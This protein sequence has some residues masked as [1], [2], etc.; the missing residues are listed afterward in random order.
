[1]KATL[2]RVKSAK[3]TVNNEIIGEIKKGYMV[4]LGVE[5]DD[6]RE[7]INYVLNKLVSLRLFPND[8]GKFHYSISQMGGQILLVSQFTLCANLNS[9]RRPSF[10]KAASP[11][12]AREYITQLTK[13][14]RSEGIAVEEGMF[15]ASM[16]VHLIN[17]GPVTINIDSNKKN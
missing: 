10:S 5:K 11:E 7:D 6:N 13:L 12:K 2:Q 15:G 3:V 16:D 8:E 17:D 1:M 9:G 4:L 14:L